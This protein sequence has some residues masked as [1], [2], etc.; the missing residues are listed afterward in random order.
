M[1]Y[2]NGIVKALKANRCDHVSHAL[3]GIEPSC[4]DLNIGRVGLGLV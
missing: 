1:A 2:V 3:H 4:R